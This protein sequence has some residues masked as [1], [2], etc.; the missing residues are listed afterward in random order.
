[1]V[2]C[3]YYPYLHKSSLVSLKTT[4]FLCPYITNYVDGCT[5]CPD[6]NCS[7]CSVCYN[8]CQCYR[9]YKN[10]RNVMTCMSI[11]LSSIPQDFP[12]FVT[13][14]ILSSNYIETLEENALDR[15]SLKHLKDL[16]LSD[17]NIHFIDVQAFRNVPSLQWLRLHNNNLKV[18]D[19][20]VFDS[21]PSL[22][23]HGL[24]LHE[25]PWECDCAFGP[26]FKRFIE[27]NNEIIFKPF[28]IKCTYNASKGILTPSKEPAKQSLDRSIIR[29]KRILDI[30]MDFLFAKTGL[31]IKQ[32]NI[33][34][35]SHW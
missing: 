22:V 32:L 21:I 16:D 13:E 23:N 5:C 12:N 2:K 18:L 31:F 15:P 10:N 30:D 4:E 8:G 9:G 20:S 6:V 33:G 28:S 34:I 1:M 17:N 25:N 26:T 19:L 29:R 11:N 7:C 3:D 24:S 35:I 14:I 27:Q